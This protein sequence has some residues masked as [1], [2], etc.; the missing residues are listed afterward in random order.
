MKMVK[1]EKQIE[2]FCIS[3]AWRSN[4]LDVRVKRSADI[5]SDHHLLVATTRLK[6]AAIHKSQEKVGKK[7]V[8]SKLQDD[9]ISSQLQMK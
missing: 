9:N 1:Q 7:F 8:V 6:I 4:L 3:K 5:G 2:H